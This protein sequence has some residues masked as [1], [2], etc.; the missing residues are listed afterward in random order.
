[1]FEETKKILELIE[2]NEKAV[3]I[4]IPEDISTIPYLKNHALIIFH[5]EV[6]ENVMSIFFNDTIV[7]HTTEK[8]KREI[9]SKLTANIFY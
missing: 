3:P 2:S 5:A 6:E 9:R 7:K 8:F 4:D 1:M